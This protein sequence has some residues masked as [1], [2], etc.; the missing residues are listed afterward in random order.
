MTI[1]PDPG[2]DWVVRGTDRDE[3]TEVMRVVNEALLIP[4]RPEEREH[5][6]RPFM[7]AEGY[8]RVL[9]AVDGDEVVGTVN[10]FAFEMTMPGGPRAVTGVTGVGVWPTH[11]RRGILSAMMRRQLADVHAR[12]DRYAALWASE[13]AIYGRFG[14]G[15]AATEMETFVRAPHTALRPDAPRD[16]DLR[17][18]LADPGQVR[19]DLERVHREVA[20]VQVGQFQRAAHWW[21]RVLRDVPGAREGRGPLRAV[22]VGGPRGPLGY[23]LYR[24]RGEREQDGAHGEVHVKEITATTPAAW[25]ALY[26]HLFGRDLVGKVSFEFLALDDPLRHLLLDPDRAAPT[27]YTSLWLRLV[28]VPGALA[29][30]SYSVPFEAVL[31]VTDGYAPWNAG[32]WHVKADTGGARVEA[33]DADPDLSLDA[34][35]LGA[36]YLGQT[37]LDGHLRAGLLTEH[38]PGA[39]ERLDR[40]LHRARAP[41]CGL[42]F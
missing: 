29:E 40:A 1:T 36:A 2:A 13:G 7:D 27:L 11:R 32:R 4:E 21:D 8:D 39:V 6:V 12:G 14:Y 10:G 18:R 9:V 38:T 37:T 28:D 24:T 33:T 5:L 17:V 3:Y 35:H 22:V 16:P 23:A 34:A 42:I 26:E 15:R 19:P 25:T 30:R 31:E 41:F 20:A